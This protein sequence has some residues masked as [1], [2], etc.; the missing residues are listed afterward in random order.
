VKA[1]LVILLPGNGAAMGRLNATQTIKN[2]LRRWGIV[3]SVLILLAPL[4]SC[5]GAAPKK[6]SKQ[7]SVSPNESEKVSDSGS[8]NAT[9]TP[10]EQSISALNNDDRISEAIDANPQIKADLEQISALS[11]KVPDVAAIVTIESVLM[12]DD[13]SSANAGQYLQAMVS[14]LEAISNQPGTA[15]L[16]E[17]IF[18]DEAAKTA[19]NSSIADFQQ[20]RTSSSL[21][22]FVGTLGESVAKSATSL[23]DEASVFTS[24]V[25]VANSPTSPD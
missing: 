16:L 18:S 21:A 8:S 3:T 15:T 17:S 23:Q 9:G 2:Q 25:S 10:I 13:F 6:S 19:I 11:E 22:R 12:I 4:P 20:N 24:L 5:T 7:N 14:V 1:F